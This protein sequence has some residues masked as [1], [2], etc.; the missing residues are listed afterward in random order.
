MTQLSKGG[1]ILDEF[2]FENRNFENKLKAKQIVM[3]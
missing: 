2:N 3:K 1:L